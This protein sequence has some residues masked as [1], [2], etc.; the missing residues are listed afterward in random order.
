M[1]GI[2]IL[3]ACHLSFVTRHLYLEPMTNDNSPNPSP[4][5][6]LPSERDGISSSGQRLVRSVG[7]IPRIRQRKPVKLLSLIP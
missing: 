7:R 5:N 1:I 6:C 3:G 4:L 2:G